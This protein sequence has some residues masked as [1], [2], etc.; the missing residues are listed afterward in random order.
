MS[1]GLRLAALLAAGAP[2]LIS[3]V[4]FYKLNTQ[5]IKIERK[6]IEAPGNNYRVCGVYSPEPRAQ[7]FNFVRLFQCS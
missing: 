2:L 5:Y 4:K 6:T 7:D 3:L 1:M